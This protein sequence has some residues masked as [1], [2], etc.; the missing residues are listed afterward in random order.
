MQEEDCHIKLRGG[1]YTPEG[2]CEDALVCGQQSCV[3]KRVHKDVGL[4]RA[5]HARRAGLDDP[6]PHGKGVHVF[7]VVGI[8]L[9]QG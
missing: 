2:L 4:G 7:L 9:G 3:A 6:T 5:H 1:L 8:H